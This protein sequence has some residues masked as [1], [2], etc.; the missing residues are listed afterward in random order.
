MEHITD[1]LN[2][3]TNKRL[4]I[5]D[6]TR[7]LNNLIQTNNFKNG[8]INVFTRHSTSA[9]AINENEPGLINDFQNKLE[10]FIPID[11]N[12]QHNRIDN[13]ADSHLR[14]FFIGSNETIPV[15]NGSMNLGTWQSV[16]FIELDGPRNRKVIVTLIGEK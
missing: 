8:L 16:F 12:Y 6:I 7:D 3:K 2:L 5:V 4:E 9:I 1:S 15:R 13:N 11:S 10:L 14:A